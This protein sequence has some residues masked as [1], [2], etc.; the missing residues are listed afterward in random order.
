MLLLKCVVGMWRMQDQ[1]DSGRIRRQNHPVHNR[2]RPINF[3]WFSK[4]FIGSPPRPVATI[5]ILKDAPKGVI[6]PKAEEEN[7]L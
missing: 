3:G 6:N 4:V 1:G 5:I 2:G 7:G